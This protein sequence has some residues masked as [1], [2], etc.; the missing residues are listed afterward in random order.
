MTTEQVPFKIYLP[1]TADSPAQFVEEIMVEIS[2]DEHGNEALTPESSDLIE[3]TQARHMGMMTGTDI[4][5]LRLRLG[6]KQGEFA[7]YLKCGAKSLSRWENGKGYPSAIINQLLRLL[8]ESRLT[9]DDLVAVDGPRQKAVE[10]SQLD[11]LIHQSNKHKE[12]G[13][14][15]YLDS[16]LPA[17]VVPFELLAS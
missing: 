8:D 15:N 1:A 13:Y 9:L 4:K 5:N 3:Q 7:S 12:H 2:V 16:T 14:Y 6:L 11:Q 10:T 17:N